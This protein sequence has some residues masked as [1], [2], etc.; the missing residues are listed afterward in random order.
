MHP[1]T[2]TPPADAS[3]ASLSRAIIG[4]ALLGW[5]LSILV[6]VTPHEEPWVGAGLVA[7]GAALL[8]TAKRFPSLP[9]ISSAWVACLGLLIVCGLVGFDAWT[10][11]RPDLPKIALI[12]WGALLAITAPLHELRIP[13]IRPG[14][15]PMRAGN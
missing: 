11:R 15:P 8:A 1:A 6:Q 5:G 4:L 3:R 9:R 13:S 14:R 10:G 2:E 12:T 7:F